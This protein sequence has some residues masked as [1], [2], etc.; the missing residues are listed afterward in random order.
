M[1]TGF[2]LIEIMIVISIIGIVSSLALI[3]MGPARDQA[4]LN[5]AQAAVAQALERARSRSATGA[6]EQS[7]GVHIETD[8]VTV[9]EGTS[10]TGAGQE[11]LLPLSVSTN[12][13]NL[14]IIFERITAQPD[15]T[16]DITL[17]HNN[18]ATKNV[19]LT[20]EGKIIKNQ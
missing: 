3:N 8:R 19:Q 4:A 18:G 17:E 1:K 5:N 14:T 6:G 15:Q 2:S 7:H 20:P 9:F 16:A 10:Y 13:N 11:T 12:H